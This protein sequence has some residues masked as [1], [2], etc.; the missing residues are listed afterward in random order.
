MDVSDTNT[1]PTLDNPGD[2]TNAEGDGV[3]LQL[4]ASDPDGD[5][6]TYSA[7]GL[8]DGLSVNPT[9]GLISGV[10]AADAGA[11]SPD[12]VTVTASDGSTSVSQS[13]TWTSL[14]S[15]SRPCPTRATSTATPCPSRSHAWTASGQ[16]L[17][18]A[19]PAS[20]PA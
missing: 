3:Q 14:T 8:P 17:T 4:T 10:V 5:A 13:F 9:T 12:A 11:G 19:A 2:Q 6:V 20:P 1:P 18:Y 15:S 7:A 16:P